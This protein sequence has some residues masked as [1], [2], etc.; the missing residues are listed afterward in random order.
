[1]S[2]FLSY[3]FIF[4]ATLSLVS[5]SR[6]SSDSLDDEMEGGGIAGD[7]TMLLLRVS[8]LNTQTTSQT[9]VEK[10]KT[11]RIIIINEDVIECNRSFDIPTTLASQLTY[12]LTWP[13][14]AGTKEVYVIANEESVEN[15]L[16][17]FLDNFA[18]NSE[19]SKS[20][21]QEWLKDY[22]FSP[23]YTVEDNSIY[24]PYTSYYGNLTVQKEEAKKIT[25]YLVPV[26]TKFIF[27]FTNNRDYPVNV[28]G[29]SFDKANKSNYLFAQVGEKDL[30]KDFDGTSYYWIDWLAKVSEASHGSAG[31]SSNEEFNKLYGWISEYE[32]PKGD[33]AETYVFK[34]EDAPIT[35]EGVTT[36]E[37]DETVSIPGRCTVGPFYVPESKNVEDMKDNDGKPVTDSDGNPVKEHVYYLTIGL[38]D[39]APGKTAP[40]FT[41]VVIPN[42][43]ALF[44]NTY[45]VINVNMS[46]GAIEVYAEIH[47]WTKKEAYGWV[48]E[49]KEPSPNPMSDNNK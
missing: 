29:I 2:R 14:L 25:A 44:R 32:I 13:T 16:G 19:S 24:L 22:Y 7:R 3:I 42:L 31:F 40:E 47:E 10:V 36:D 4:F 15:G 28:N 49:G 20:K 33:E 37:T 6:N 5:C 41:N 1:M 43:K 26:A 45:V 18:E 17:K 35:V 39:T 46:Q 9:P 27:N 8:P 38:K 34:V 30:K 12:T 21:F 48:V 23:E 11:L